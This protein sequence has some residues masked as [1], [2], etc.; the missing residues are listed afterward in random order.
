MMKKIFMLVIICLFC[1]VVKAQ[2]TYSKINP[3]QV[4]LEQIKHDCK[5]F[6]GD[7]LDGFALEATIT[8]GIK[9]FDMYSELKAY[10]YIKEIAFIKQKY[11]IKKLPQELADEQRNG[12]H[13]SVLTSACNNIDFEN[14]NFTGWTGKIGYN[15]NS[16]GALT[17]TSTTISTAGVNSAETSCSFHTLMTAAGG[18]DPYGAFS[19][20]DPGGGTYAVRLGGEKENTD[21]ANS[22]C[23]NNYSFKPGYSNGESIE[24]TFAVTAANTLFT[25]KYAVVLQSAP[26]QPG[27]QPYFN[28]EVLDKNGTAIPCLNYYVQGDSGTYPPGFQKTVNGLDT[29]AYITWQTSSLN[30]LPYIGTNVTIRFTAAGC[31]YG[32]H[33]GYA[34]IDCSCSPLVLIIPSSPVC[35]GGTE[36]LTA[37]AQ[38]QGTYAWTGPG[39]VGSTTTQSITATVSGVYSVTIT[40][41]KGC[42]YELDTNLVFFPNPTV[43]VNSAS[44]CAGGQAT[45]TAIGTGAGTLSY[46]WNPSAGFTF[47]NAGDSSGTITPTVTSSYTVTGTSLHGCTNT[48][49][50]K[51]TVS[52]GNPPAFSAA[53]VCLGSATSFV[54]TTGGTGNTYGW[55]F[56]DTPAGTSTATSPTYTYLSPGTFSVTLTV[57]TTSGCVVTLTHTVGV[58]AVP[59]ASFSAGPVCLGTATSFTSVTTPPT[60]LN[61]NWNFGDTPPGIST[62]PEPTYT[63]GATGIFN[64]TLTVSIGTCTAT[65]TNTVAVNQIPVAD[66][67]LSPVCQGSATSFTNTSTPATGPNWVWNFGDPASGASNASTAQ[68][69]THIYTGSGSFVITLTVVAGGNCT[70][71]YSSTAVVNTFPVLSFTADHPCNGTGVNFTNTTTNQA[72]IATWSWTLGDGTT[73][74]AVTP[75]VETYPAAGCYSV[76]LTATA[77]T[78]CSGSHDTVVYVHSNPKAAFTASTVCI[79]SPSGFT[80]GS[81]LTNIGCITDHI[82]SWNWNF[83]DNQTANNTTAPG[84]FSH[85]YATCG[86]YNITLTVTTNNNCVSSF[87]LTGDTVFCTPVVTPPANLLVCPNTS[88]PTQLFTATVTNGGPAH[89]KWLASTVHSGM[90]ASYMTAGGLDS[91]P[92]YTSTLQNLTCKNLVDTVTAIPVS[93]AG[94][95]GKKAFYTVTLYPTPYLDH[96]PTDSVCANQALTVPGFTACPAN[97]TIAWTNSNTGIG[98]AGTGTG[99]L[100]TFTGLNTGTTFNIGQIDAIPTANGCVGPDSSF[101]IVIK[102]IPV[103]S[104]TNITVCPTNQINIPLNVIPA[105]SSVDWFNNNT[106]IGLVSSGKGQPVAYTAPTNTTLANIQGIITYTPSLNGCVGLPNQDTVVIKP[107][108]YMQHIPNQ[109]LCPDQFSNAVPLSIFPTTTGPAVTYNW[110]YKAIGAITGTVNPFPA[111]GPIPNAGQTILTYPVTVFPTLNGCVG[112]DSIFSISVYPRPVADYSYSSKVCLGQFTAFTDLSTCGSN[113]PVTQ[114][115]W[116]FGS[117]L[118][119][120]NYTFTLIGTQ[121]VTLIITTNPSP[122][123]I[124]G[125]CKDTVTKYP[126]VN[127]IPV[128]AFTGDSLK[129]CP[130]LSTKFSSQSTVSPGSVQSYTWTFGN[131]QSS[132]LLM[133][134]A[135]SYTNSSATQ[136]AYYSVSLVV[137]SDS[138]CVSPKNTRSN[139]IQVYPRPIAD[140]SWGPSGADIDDPR[141]NFVNESQGASEYLPLKPFGPN[142]IQ[143]DLGDVFAAIPSQNTVYTNQNFFHM[144]EHYD[145]YTYYVTQWVV[146]SYGCKDSI[147]K[148]VEILPDFTFYIPN[149]F[150]P[151]GDGTN[152]GFKGTGI[153]IDLTTYNLWVFDRWGL[154]I[155][156][157]DDL[158]KTWDGHMRGNEGQPV[159][160]QDVYVWKVK[161]RDTITGKKHEYHG[162]VTLL[163]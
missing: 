98:L 6:T 89:S 39:I 13:P 86:P 85:T 138:G 143:Y 56:G 36:S 96:M 145:P 9:K 43:T 123:P 111:I 88:V 119:D 95:I 20:V 99:N 135:Q 100:G 41:A 38:S 33:F 44:L 131:G 65:A 32:G 15:S 158:E 126:Y 3:S 12:N 28:V 159:L 122:L 121:T 8:G 90:P 134:P 21:F 62:A 54:N 163:K 22:S 59:T 103:V 161:F 57:T 92:K 144:Y 42:K 78:G 84:T 97:S 23:T 93:S 113:I 141:I 35:L 156:Y 106:A 51:I 5:F 17:V 24:Q 151:N 52:P 128:A 104:V 83:G 71:T 73:S 105:N 120:P 117:I 72:A 74:A 125:G 118:Q 47:A 162:T 112:P 16:N 82:T 129:S 149:A 116:S 29:T 75:P 50:S 18:T 67:T 10:M 136:S 152:D 25:Y 55:N 58:Y 53:P 142:G 14:G 45:L 4:P 79:G 11:G 102:P 150:S 2:Y 137:A 148:P 30:L 37:P 139:Y 157:S 147:T 66:F 48:A 109:Y 68:N 31:I 60:G 94:C 87:T 27:E 1:Q 114:W 19:V 34:Y 127:P 77:T 155:F 76:A 115:N 101:I 7:T 140:F 26:H 80:D 124:L 40:N 108:P 132:N 63:Y 130:Q 49:V 160:Q 110:S 81:S 154:Q 46:S 70:A 146:N 107:T 61:Y 91:I 133:P 153:G 69:P 64:V